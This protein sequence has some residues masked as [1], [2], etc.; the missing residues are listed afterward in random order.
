MVGLSCRLRSL[1]L[2][3]RSCT[4]RGF[5]LRKW[6]TQKRRQKIVTPVL[7][8]NVSVRS[9]FT[10]LNLLHLVDFTFSDRIF[11]DVFF[12]SQTLV[13]RETF[14]ASFRGVLSFIGLK[15]LRV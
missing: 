8:Q 2:V 10:F 5:C 13:C 14:G 1:H 12:Q 15:F 11:C 9:T 7:V 3:T 6:E 4:H